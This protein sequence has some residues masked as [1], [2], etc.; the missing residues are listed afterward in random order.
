MDILIVTSAILKHD[1]NNSYTI[2][3]TIKYLIF[4]QILKMFS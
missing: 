3:E 1:N 4:I 2:Y